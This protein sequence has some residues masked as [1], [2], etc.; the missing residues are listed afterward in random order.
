MNQS[1]RLPLIF[2]F[3]GPI[4]GRGFLADV[5]VLGRLVAVKEPDGVWFDGVNPG[6]IAAG[7]KTIPEANSD[8]SKGFKGVLID[9]ANDAA[10][11]EDFKQKV[12]QFVMG[13]DDAAYAE[14][15][16]AVAAVRAGRSDVSSVN[17]PTQPAS[18]PVTV[19]VLQL[20]HEALTPEHNVLEEEPEPALAA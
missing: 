8:F 15:V 17:L 16:E 13:S 3:H 11:F 1:V 20:A 19:K 9:I 12:E 18:Q 2:T 6:G 5:E 4:I 7:G 14:W 10:T